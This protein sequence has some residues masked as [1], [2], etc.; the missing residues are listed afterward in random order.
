MVEISHLTKN[1]GS[2]KAVND[3][4][5]TVEEGEIMGFLGPNG[6]GKSTTLNILT[7]F[8]SAT[9]GSALACG[10]GAAFFFEAAARPDEALPDLDEDV[11]FFAEA[12]A[13]S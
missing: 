3:I 5:F 13:S 1:Y 8:L 4:S 12:M 10:V 2:K 6:A 11:F 7:G 9:S